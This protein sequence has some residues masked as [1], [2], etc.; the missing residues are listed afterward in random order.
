MSLLPLFIPIDRNR[1][2]ENYC[3]KNMKNIA[4]AA[5][6]HDVARKRLLGYTKDFGILSDNFLDPV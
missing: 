3:R 5:M 2:R 6:Q 1:A 4:L